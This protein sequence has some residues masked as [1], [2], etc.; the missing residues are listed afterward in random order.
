[1]LLQGTMVLVC[2]WSA[3]Q[4]TKVGWKS[5]TAESGEQ[6]VTTHLI[7]SMRQSSAMHLALGQ[8]LYCLLVG[9]VK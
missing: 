5:T 6:S 1:M 3:A 9:I 8:R 2:D 7:V 4:T